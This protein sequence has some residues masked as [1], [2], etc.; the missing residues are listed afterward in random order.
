[1]SSISSPDNSTTDG[2]GNAPVRTMLIPIDETA[3]AEQGITE[4]TLLQVRQGRSDSEMDKAIPHVAIG[5]LA[6]LAAR[7]EGNPFYNIK[8]LIITHSRRDNGYLVN[9]PRAMLDGFHSL[10]SGFEVTLEDGTVIFLT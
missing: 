7:T 10:Q 3:M 2:N 1:M 8:H 4:T 6:E 5:L 9:H